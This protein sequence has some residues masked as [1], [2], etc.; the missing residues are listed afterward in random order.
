MKNLLSILYI[1]FFLA[2]CNP[3]TSHEEKIKESIHSILQ[4]NNLYKS[5]RFDM[6]E[7]TILLSGSVAAMDSKT[8]LEQ[9]VKAIDQIG[10]V[11]N[12]IEINGGFAPLTQNIFDITKNYP[13]IEAQ[14]TGDSILILRGNI[15]KNNWVGLQQS[16]SVIKVKKMDTTNLSIN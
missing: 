14:V 9:A 16:L 6:H 10:E 15:K 2:A 1:F 5:V 12:H 13:T 8:N 3:L 7:D 11:I 4:S